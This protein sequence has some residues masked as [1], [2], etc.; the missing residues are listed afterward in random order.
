MMLNIYAKL[1]ED[2]YKLTTL[3]QPIQN[4]VVFVN[5]YNNPL[6]SLIWSHFG[7]SGILSY[8]MLNE[9]DSIIDEIVKN[10]KKSIDN[11]K[12]NIN[13]YISY[14]QGLG[15]KLSLDDFIREIG[16][17]V[18]ELENKMEE[19]SEYKYWIKFMKEIVLSCGNNDFS[20]IRF[21]ID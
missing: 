14:L 16:N 11:R 4:E 21:E 7:S 3:N 12:E 15:E 18:E 17:S 6:C 5:S 2:L 13:N 20:E 1:R 19:I 9:C 8:E 10:Y